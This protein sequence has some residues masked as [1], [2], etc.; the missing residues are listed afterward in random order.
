[1]KSL[2]Q[3]ACSSLAMLRIGGLAAALLAGPMGCSEALYP[4]RP[5]TIPG[6]PIADP[7][8]SKVVM[9]VALTGPGLSQLLDSTVPES[10]EGLFTFV[11]TRAYRWK[12]GPFEVSFDNAQGKVMV[13]ADVQG[14]AD[15]PGTT[16]H[17]AM[18]L[19]VS[20][21]PVVTTDYQALL[22]APVVTV[23]TN[24]K[25]LRAAEWSAGVLTGLRGAAEKA[26]KGARF[27]LRPLLG[28]AYSRLAQ[29]IKLPIGQAQG[30]VD[31]GVRNVEA[32]PTVLAGGLE[33]ELAMV[34]APSVTLP[35]APGPAGASKPTMPPLHNVASLPSG[36]FEVTIP[37]A[38]TYDELQ[39]AMTQ[40]FTGGKLYFS[41]EFPDLYLEKPEVYAS[42]GQIVVKLHLNGFVKKGF[43][44]NLSGDLFMAG[45]P[46]VRDNELEV[47][48][49][50]PTIETQSALLKLKTR[51]DA[52]GLRKQVRDALRL[53]I[54][55]RLLPVREKLSKDLTF[56]QNV[57]KVP[58][59][60]RADLERV[61]ITGVFAHDS[62]LRLYARVYARAA[63][64]LPCPAP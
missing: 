48:D 22:Q 35:C 46:Q 5:P 28:Q 32:G 4:P 12:R 38:A 45:H 64:Y 7:A 14:E 58:S 27:D 39:K 34:V 2:C 33:K 42:G 25:V 24:D 41:K 40:A 59:C 23:T 61:E 10:G 20:A 54:G 50:Q 17:F 15:V 13:H 63:A 21:Q 62:Y 31:L 1:M 30:C 8:P 11:G 56:Q 57:G 16:L 44:L 55:Q 37:I 36:P 53:D 26:L 9:H 19:G 3:T 6:P 43:R 18:S 49:V 51:L 52:D 60:V 47:P 29:P